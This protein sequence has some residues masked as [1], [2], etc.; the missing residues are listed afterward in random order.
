MDEVGGDAVQAV[1][2]HD[3]GAISDGMVQ[4]LEDETL[5]RGMV[6]RGLRRAAM[7]SWEACVEKTLAVYQKVKPD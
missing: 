5:R 3:I 6:E 4:V 7:F 1:D 2:A